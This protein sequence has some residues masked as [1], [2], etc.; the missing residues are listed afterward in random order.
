[1]DPC[2]APY[3][4]QLLQRLHHEY[5]LRLEHE[6]DDLLARIITNIALVIIPHIRLRLPDDDLAS[7]FFG[8]LI[9]HNDMEHAHLSI[10]DELHFEQ[11]ADN[12]ES[13]ICQIITLYVDNNFL[14][15]PQY[16]KIFQ[17]NQF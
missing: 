5:Q 15:S 16:T 4:I 7:Q 10:S 11:M 13:L 12:F 2:E 17:R 8:Y 3:M 6:A 14:L 1:M 9:R